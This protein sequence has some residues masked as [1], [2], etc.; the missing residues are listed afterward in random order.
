MENNKERPRVLIEEWFPFEE[1]GI[2]CKRERIGK[3]VPLNRL[4]VWWARRPLICSRASI[5]GSILPPESR[6]E[7]YKFIQI[8]N[9]LKER[10]E[11]WKKLKSE[12]KTPVGISSS[13]AFT[14]K[15]SDSNFSN[16]KTIL[17][18]F[19][20][21]KEIVLLDPMAGGGSIPFEAVKLGL[22]VFASD[23]N[24]IPVILLIS[25]IIH[26]YKFRDSLISNV[27]KYAQIILEK[28]KYLEK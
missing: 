12:G 7:F 4:H 19:W 18:N 27:R 23:I 26:S 16:Y 1:V 8:D 15:L 22:K 20:H 14:K 3:F 28:S 9:N 10:M 21:K 6:N 13:R 24:P 25:S 11:N 17:E 2:E 5:I